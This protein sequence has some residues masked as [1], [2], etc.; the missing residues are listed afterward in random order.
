[1]NSIFKLFLFAL[2]L[3]SC[4]CVNAEEKKSL[5][6]VLSK[7]ESA[8]EEEDGD[9]LERVKLL[10]ENGEYEASR[11]VLADA[12]QGEFLPEIVDYWIQADEKKL[13]SMTIRHTELVQ[14]NRIERTWG[15]YGKE[16]AVAAGMG[17]LTWG[18]GYWV[19][20]TAYSH[21]KEKERIEKMK[22]FD[23]NLL[24]QEE[25]HSGIEN[26]D[27]LKKSVQVLQALVNQQLRKSKKED[28][29]QIIDFSKRIKEL[30]SNIKNKRTQFISYDVISPYLADVARWLVISQGKWYLMIFEDKEAFKMA[31]KNLSLAC[32]QSLLMESTDEVRLQFFE[33]QKILKAQTSKE[34]LEELKVLTS[35]QDSTD[36][37]KKRGAD[38]WW[39]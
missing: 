19:G 34:E 17:V 32:H 33:V 4:I 7:L 37:S 38:A 36:P 25:V 21:M 20:G 8:E 9:L 12:L 22:E 39:E 5:D 13:Q 29:P 27:N 23:F 30:K 35:L 18:V 15:E 28:L 24:S 10:E 14:F 11:V 2:I 1:M 31:V 26:Y 3:F 16:Q 6:D